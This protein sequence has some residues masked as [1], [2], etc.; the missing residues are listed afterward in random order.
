MPQKSQLLMFFAAV[1]CMA[2]GV[3]VFESIFNNYLDDTFE[4]AF[5]YE[6]VFAAAAIL[7]LGISAVSTLVPRHGALKQAGGE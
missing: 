4:M 5:G 2:A 6:R 3:S 7:A 1:I